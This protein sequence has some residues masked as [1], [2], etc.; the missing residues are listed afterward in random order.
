MPSGHSSG[1]A[2]LCVF[3]ILEFIYLKNKDFI[4]L[5]TLK[6]KIETYLFLIMSPLVPY[7]RIY[8]NYHTVN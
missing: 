5:K 3:L 7:S 8:L 6:Y 4:A 1:T 2:S